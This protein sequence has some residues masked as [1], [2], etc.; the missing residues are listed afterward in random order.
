MIFLFN[1]LKLA[2]W[3][4]IYYYQRSDLVFDIIIKNINDC[5]CLAI[6]FTQ[7]LLPKIELI[8]ENI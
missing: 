7:W 8:Y 4:G 3:S 1:Y 5:G 2:L 6:K